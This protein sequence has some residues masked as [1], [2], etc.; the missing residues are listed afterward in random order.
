VKLSQHPEYR[1]YVTHQTTAQKYEQAVAAWEMSTEPVVAPN[2]FRWT[3][4]QAQELVQSLS[5]LF[6]AY[7]RVLW[8][9]FP[10][11]SR[12][13]GGCCVVDASDVKPMDYVALALLG[14]SLPER[15]LQIEITS[16][17]CIYLQ[18]TSCSWPTTW[19]PLKCAAFYC[20]GSGDWALDSRDTRYGEVTV[21]LQQVVR[22]HL[23]DSLTQNKVT[24]D[25]AAFLSDPIGFAQ[26]LSDLLDDILVMPLLAA[27]SH[28]PP[29][30]MY[31]Q[32]H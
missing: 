9:Q 4:A 6:Q 22:D 31:L 18:G 5:R 10:Y 26:A 24:D 28:H 30:Q 15:P 29:P 25:L 23:P 21:A 16:R 12:C 27:V 7:N 32:M 1:L 20:L 8:R 11:C 17:A 14:E 2:G 13:G 3:Y 19:R